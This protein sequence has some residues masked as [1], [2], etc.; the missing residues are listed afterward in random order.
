MKEI[1]KFILIVFVCSFFSCNNDS[2]E[3]LIEDT[4][5]IKNVDLG[6]NYLKFIRTKKAE[7]SVLIQSN[8]TT[9]MQDINKNI[10][11]AE[12]RSLTSLKKT[13]KR[14]EIKGFDNVNM[15]KTKNTV[16]DKSNLFG[17]VLS[18]RIA[19]NSI[20][21]RSSQ[22]NSYNEVYIPKLI[23][24][25]YSTEN[26][27]PGTIIS[28]NTDSL[29]ENGVAISV[30]YYAVNQLDTEIAFANTA[31]IKRNFVLDDSLGTYTFSQEDLEI[32]PKMALLDINVLRAGFDT[33]ENSDMSIAGMTKV[34]VTK[35]VK[36]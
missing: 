5:S 2:K 15:R 6:K 33:D 31:T 16:D 14:I 35:L 7:G 32:F 13:S 28:W 27:E 12:K 8:T 1:L 3:N 36:Y 4:V 19:D 11:F 23:N 21:S 18:Y 20:A 25:T 29:N 17:Q 34:G 22:E 24:V 26:L 10:S 30:E 9:V